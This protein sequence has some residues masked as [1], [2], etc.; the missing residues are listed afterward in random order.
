[1]A[2][3]FKLGLCEGRHEIKDVDTYIF[4]DGDIQFPINPS[5][6]RKK[7]VERFKEIGVKA[8]DDLVIYVTGLTPAL[9]AVIRIAFINCMTLTLMHYDNAS[10]NYIEDIIFSPNDVCHD[11]E[12]PA[13]V[14]CP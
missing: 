7:V 3:T 9:T 12:Y 4:R 14:A 5:D 8:S 11:I 2:T 10:G 6:L 13:W 1:M